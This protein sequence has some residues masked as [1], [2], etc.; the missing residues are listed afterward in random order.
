MPA[1]AVKQMIE[2]GV[3]FLIPRKTIHS[4]FRAGSWK[5][6]GLGL[7]MNMHVLSV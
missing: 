5:S 3:D 7:K 1:A 4:V 2:A 6:Q